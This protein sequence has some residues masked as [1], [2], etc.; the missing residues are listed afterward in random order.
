MEA[1]SKDTAAPVNGK[2][3]EEGAASREGRITVNSQPKLEKGLE[4]ARLAK[5]KAVSRLDGERPLDVAQRMYG[6]NS[7]VFGTI[8]A[9]V[10]AGTTAS[11]P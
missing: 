3:Q 5:V 9:T 2:S 6:E 8:K 1:A 11:A 10:A 4:F 7:N